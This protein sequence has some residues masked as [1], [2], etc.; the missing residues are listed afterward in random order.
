MPAYSVTVGGAS[1]NSAFAQRLLRIVLSETTGK[2][3]DTLEM[4]FDDRN[5]VLAIPAKGAVI[6]LAIG[7]HGAALVAKGSFTFDTADIEGPPDKIIL[8]AKSGDMRD[9]L[10]AHK[11][12]AWVNMTTAAIVNQIASENGLTAQTHPTLSGVQVA[13]KDQTNE[14]DLHFLTRHGKDHDAIATVKGGKLIFAP[15]GAIRIGPSSGPCA[16]SIGTFPPPPWPM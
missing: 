6:T 5:N 12:R 16:P 2:D 3:A 13:H 9:S 11:N 1:P 14:S 7:Y 10:K 15:R 8:H 4:E